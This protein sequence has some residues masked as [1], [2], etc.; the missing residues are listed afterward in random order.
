MAYNPESSNRN[1]GN[2][3]NLPNPSTPPDLA[4]I[5]TNLAQGQTAMQ[6]SMRQLIQT[7]QGGAP[8]YSGQRSDHR[9]SQSRRT[10]S[11]RNEESNDS[12]YQPGRTSSI[13]ATDTDQRITLSPERTSA[14][15]RLSRVSPF[16]RLNLGGIGVDLGPCRGVSDNHQI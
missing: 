3:G 8:T 2:I 11:Y 9:Q 14:L 4:G 10:G 7:L 5:M 15:E 12:S 1:A 6:E 16:S 13:R